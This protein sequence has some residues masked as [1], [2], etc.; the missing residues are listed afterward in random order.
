MAPP[1]PAAGDALYSAVIRIPAFVMPLLVL[2]AVLVL[3]HQVPPARGLAAGAAG[4]GAASGGLLG[5]EGSVGGDP[6]ERQSLLGRG[7][8]DVEADEYGRRRA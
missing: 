1:F 4:A 8:E 2:L 5:A 3:Y 7:G 6:S